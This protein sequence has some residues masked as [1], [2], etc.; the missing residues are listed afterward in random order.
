VNTASVLC[1]FCV[2]YKIEYPHT[3][4]HQI[5]FFL[6]CFSLRRFV[7]GTHSSNVVSGLGQNEVRGECIRRAG[8][9]AARDGVAWSLRFGQTSQL[10]VAS[11]AGQSARETRR[12]SRAGDRRRAPKGPREAAARNRRLRGAVVYSTVAVTLC[13]LLSLYL[14]C[15]S[16][17]LGSGRG[18]FRKLLFAG[19]FCYRDFVQ[20]IYYGD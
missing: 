15:V 17:D 16:F 9:V 11:V 14:W 4:L 10:R 7:R 20:F 19:G 12:R 6:L 2:S 1:V 5:V 8:G 3:T 18:M 13:V